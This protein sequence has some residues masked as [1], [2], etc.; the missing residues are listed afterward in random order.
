[1]TKA[2]KPTRTKLK[3]K[4]T[5]KGFSCP[6]CRGVRLF[7]R[8]TTRPMPGLIRRYRECTA[9]GY[10]VTTEERKAK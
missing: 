5:V 2:P 1:M 9:C 6:D 7:V 3:P 10:R 4:P 8:E